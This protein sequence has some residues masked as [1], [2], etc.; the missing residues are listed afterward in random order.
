MKKILVTG[1]C[2]LHWGRLQYGNI[3]NYYIIEPLFR[4]LHKYFPGY[5]ITTT[6]Q[7]TEEFARKEKIE[8]VPMWLYYNWDSQN[9]LKN[10]YDDV[11]KARGYIRKEVCYSGLTEYGKLVSQCEFV[12]NVSGDMWGDNA[13]HVG[14]QRFLV[15][16]LKM[17]TAQVL[18]IKTI[19]YA[20]TPGPFNRIEDKKLAL[21]VF[22]NFSMVVIR[23]KLSKE[24]L[25]KWGFPT[26]HVVWAP[27]PS[28]LFE[29]NKEYQSKWIRRIERLH[30]SNEKVIGLTFGGFNMPVGP[31]DMC[32]RDP[33]QYRVFLNVAEYIIN[34]LK[35]DIMIFSHTNG[36]ELPPQ[37]KLIN[38]RD[39][40]ILN[41]FYKLLVDRNQNYR[42]HVI[43]VDEPLLPCNIKKLI[44]RL[45]ML[46]TGRVHA[47]VAAT[48]QCVPTVYMEYNQNVI[49]SDKMYGFSSQIGM[50]KYVSAPG[51]FNDLAA[52]ITD[53]YDNIDLVRRQLEEKIPVIKKQAEDIFEDIRKICV[54]KK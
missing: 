3:G 44:G 35:A 42:E 34:E 40:M 30:Q 36:F 49:Y 50:E 51:N 46:I 25:V 11:E 1:L 28:F 45:D 18:G 47:S 37:F 10:A 27:C 17:L 43:L 29:P 20:V 5:A 39:F 31:Y 14:H 6:F 54:N 26:D 38:G 15:D 48:S 19:L 24:N 8:I 53:C 13:E 23:E 9:D 12:L 21:Q 32:P 7:M 22:K 4:L 16:C 2:T 52:I 33:E 41:Q